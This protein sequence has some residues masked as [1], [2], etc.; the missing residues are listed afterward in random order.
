MFTNR[1]AG[2][3]G[4]AR[5]V[6]GGAAL[7]AKSG[8]RLNPRR[9]DVVG[10][11]LAKRVQHF[12]RHL[13]L[14]RRRTC[15]S[16][17]CEDEPPPRARRPGTVHRGDAGAAGVH[18]L[19]FPCLNTPAARAARSAVLTCSAKRRAAGLLVVPY[20]PGPVATEPASYARQCRRGRSHF[21][22]RCA[23]LDR[24]C[25]GDATATSG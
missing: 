9:S 2:T 3:D 24:T 19:A 7:C 16:L 5:P 13:V 12:T 22:P 8:P 25:A 1:G 11:C 20:V 18:R 14:G 10:H 23:A 4:A 6:T 17:T 15:R 21:T